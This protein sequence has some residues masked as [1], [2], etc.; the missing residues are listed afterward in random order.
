MQLLYWKHMRQRHLID[1]KSK[2]VLT[3]VQRIEAA[4]FWFTV[5]LTLFYNLFVQNFA[6]C[7]LVVGMFKIQQNFSPE[8]CVRLSSSKK[9]TKFAIIAGVLKKCNVCMSCMSILPFFCWF[10]SESIF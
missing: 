6:F 1:Y 2:H 7:L 10:K 8:T 9:N 3:D 4:Q 5:D